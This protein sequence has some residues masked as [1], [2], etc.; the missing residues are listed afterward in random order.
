MFILAGLNGIFSLFAI[1]SIFHYKRSKGW[2]QGQRTI[3][4]RSSINSRII[5][6]S[7]PNY[8]QLK[9]IFRGFLDCA[10]WPPKAIAT[11]REPLIYQHILGL[12]AP[13]WTV[14]STVLLR[15]W[16]FRL[17]DRAPPDKIALAEGGTLLFEM[18]VIL[19]FTVRASVPPSASAILS[20]GARSLSLKI[21]TRSKTVEH[22]VAERKG[23]VYADKWAALVHLRWLLEASEHNPGNHGI[24]AS[25][26][27]NLERIRRL[28]GNLLSFA[29]KWSVDLVASLYFFYSGRYFL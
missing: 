9:R 24:Y 13:P 16:I 7:A 6:E 27:R 25:A 17:S 11:A 12:F 15:V 23:Q 29:W 21:Q 14:C 4:T 20:G 28:F 18:F 5:D 19:N 1:R 26:D 8:D 10:R 3:S 22:T 2:L